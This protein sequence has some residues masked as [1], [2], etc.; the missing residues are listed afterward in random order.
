MM[1][2]AKNLASVAFWLS[3]A[4]IIL[5]AAVFFMG[6]DNIIGLAGTQWVLVAIA[7]GVYAIYFN[8]TSCGSG[9]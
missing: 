9:E 2:N 5:A 6:M 4:A 1:K 7:L 3:V 8:G